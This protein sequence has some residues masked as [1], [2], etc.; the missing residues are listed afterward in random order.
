MRLILSGHI[1]RNGLLV[2]G[3]GKLA[4]RN[5]PNLPPVAQTVRTIRGV[6]YGE[7]R[8][9]RPP[10]VAATPA[11]GNT[12]LGPLFVNTTSAGPRGNLCEGSMPVR[13]AGTCDHQPRQRWN[14][15]QGFTAAD[16]SE[17][18]GTGQCRAARGDGGTAAAGGAAGDE[19]HVPVSY[20]R[21]VIPGRAEGASP[22][23]RTKQKIPMYLA[24]RAR[25]FAASRNDR[26]VRHHFAS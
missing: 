15:R 25:R 23:S 2:M 9:L 13:A 12:Y 4:L 5:F 11:T 1:H 10:A 21:A 26:G 24:F 8:G 22:E 20:A 18:A 16:H 6:G 7:V 17:A 14:D 19:L 3:T